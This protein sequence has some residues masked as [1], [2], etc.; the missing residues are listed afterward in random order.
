MLSVP[1]RR[2]LVKA[3]KG[4]ISKGVHAGRLTSKVAKIIGGK[5]GGQPHFGQGGGG[6]PEK[7]RDASD[8]IKKALKAQLG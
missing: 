8:A 7:F 6:D 1:Q 3:G 2:F 4:A 5:G